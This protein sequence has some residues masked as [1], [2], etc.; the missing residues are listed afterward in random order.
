MKVSEMNGREKKAFYNVYHAAKWIIG[1]LEDTL[2]DFEE[3]TAEHESAKATL[4]NHDGLVKVLYGEATTSV[5][6]VG[7]HFF[8]T[9]AERY[10]RDIRFCGKDFLMDICEARIKKMGY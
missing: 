4:M 10:L 7:G 5:Y 8:G 3:G 9:G 1:G 6:S 2:N